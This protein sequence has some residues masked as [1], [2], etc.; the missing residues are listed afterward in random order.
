MTAKHN[1]RIAENTQTL[2]APWIR[3]VGARAGW[4]MMLGMA[5]IWW[6]AK[7]GLLVGTWLLLVLGCWFVLMMTIPMADFFALS[8]GETRIERRARQRKQARTRAVHHA[9][10]GPMG[11]PIKTNAIA[12]D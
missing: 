9:A 10:S 8:P 12:V 2:L 3:T 11:L 4:P 1:G 6:S 7:I 5:L